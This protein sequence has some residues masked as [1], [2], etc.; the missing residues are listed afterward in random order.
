M[1]ASSRIGVIK[2][3]Y[4]NWLGFIIAIIE[5]EDNFQDILQYISSFPPSVKRKPKFTG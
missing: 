2:R 3:S 1:K 5:R 4:Q